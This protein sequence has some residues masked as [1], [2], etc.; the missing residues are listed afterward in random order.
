MSLPKIL[1]LLTSTPPNIPASPNLLAFLKNPSRLVHRMGLPNLL[2]V[3]L[4][5]LICL[6][7]ILMGL[8]S[9]LMSL[10]CLF[11]GLLSLLMSLLIVLMGLL[12][13]LMSLPG[14]TNLLMCLLRNLPWVLT[15]LLMIFP[16]RL[17]HL[18]NLINLTNH[19]MTN[20]NP[21]TTIPLLFTVL[22]SL[23]IKGLLMTLSLPNK[24]TRGLLTDLPGRLLVLLSHLFMALFADLPSRLLSLPNLIAGRLMVLLNPLN[25]VRYLTATS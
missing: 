9:L 22:P 18:L 3:S 7:C 17:T 4:S 10:M 2:I 6:P 25:T 21:L 23:L 13:L 5:L 8:L 14:F 16:S 11:T 24:N 1:M 20:L 19:F 15:N 12:S